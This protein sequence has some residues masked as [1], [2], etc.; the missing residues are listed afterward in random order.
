MLFFMSTVKFSASARSGGLQKIHKYNFIFFG[1]D[2]NTHINKYIYIYIYILLWRFVSLLQRTPGQHLTRLH[3]VRKMDTYACLDTYGQF[4]LVWYNFIKSHSWYH[5]TFIVVFRPTIPPN[6]IEAS[7]AIPVRTAQWC[8]GWNL[9][10]I[11]NRNNIWQRKERQ[12]Y[13]KTFSIEVSIDFHVTTDHG[14]WLTSAHF[15]CVWF[16]VMIMLVITK[17][18]PSSCN[19]QMHVVVSQKQR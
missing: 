9:C 2:K 11:W 1:C 3:G 7:L 12:R 18:E 4:E 10:Y 13:S 15:D 17:N 16:G 14:A 19:T 8:W 6:I 5:F